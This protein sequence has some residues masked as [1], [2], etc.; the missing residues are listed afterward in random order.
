MNHHT[1]DTSSIL[2]RDGENR[3]RGISDNGYVERGDGV[4]VPISDQQTKD[5][6]W[7][8]KK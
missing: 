6:L 7:N 3:M 2:L 1:F 8:D 4:F 5:I